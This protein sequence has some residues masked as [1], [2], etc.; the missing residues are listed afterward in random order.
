M[1]RNTN[2]NWGS[3]ARWLHWSLGIAIIFMMAYGWWMNHIP[4]RPDRFFHRSI[5]S[6]IGYAIL[7]LMML[8]LAWRAFNPVPEQPDGTPRWRRIAASANHWLL[9]GVTFVVSMLGW[10]HSGA[11]TPDYSN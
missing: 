8:R 2:S 6:N 5:H 4:A 7:L 9:Y 3:V 10:A 11:H 1:I